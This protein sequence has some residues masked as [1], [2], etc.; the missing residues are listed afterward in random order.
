MARP[1]VSIVV[2]TYNRVELL[3]RDRAINTRADVH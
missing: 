3:P 1:L 2:P